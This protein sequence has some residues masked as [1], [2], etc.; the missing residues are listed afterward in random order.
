MRHREPRSLGCAICFR[1]G[2]GLIEQPAFF[3]DDKA[4]SR[5]QIVEMRLEDNFYHET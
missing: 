2:L 5:S 4:P 1:H 3:M